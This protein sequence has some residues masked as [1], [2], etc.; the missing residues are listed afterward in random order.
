M[1]MKTELYK[2]LKKRWVSPIDA[3]QL[4]GCMSLSQRCGEFRREGVLVVDAWCETNGKRYKS[5]RIFFS[6]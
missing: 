1:T 6:K 2:L 4:V 3:L 5:Y